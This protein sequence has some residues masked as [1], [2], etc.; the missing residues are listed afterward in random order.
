MTVRFFRVT[1]EGTNETKLQLIKTWF[2]NEIDNQDIEHG[3]ETVYL[4]ENED[5]LGVYTL[6]CDLYLGLSVDVDKYTNK[7][8]NHSNQLDKAGI[9]FIRVIQYDN[10]SHDSNNPQPCNSTTRFEWVSS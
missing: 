4:F 1:I 9:N 2:E 8:S 5:T 10:C 7:I 6:V 3:D